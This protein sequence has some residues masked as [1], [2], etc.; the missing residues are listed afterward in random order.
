MTSFDNMYQ[1]SILKVTKDI[2]RNS[3]KSLS[4]YQSSDKDLIEKTHFYSPI[5]QQP[6]IKNTT[7]STLLVGVWVISC[8]T[9][10]ISQRK[11]SVNRATIVCLEN[12]LIID[13]QWEDLQLMQTMGNGSANSKDALIGDVEW[14]GNC[15]QWRFYLQRF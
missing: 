8:K 9:G 4:N 13:W 6:G 2:Q 3:L 5:I 7:V 11:S 15:K 12:Q 1:I 14:I 10:K